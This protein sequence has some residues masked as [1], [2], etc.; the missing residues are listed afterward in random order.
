MDKSTK[1]IDAYLQPVLDM[2]SE[3]QEQTIC[4][5]AGNCMAPLIREGDLLVIKHGNQDI[6]AG[7]VAVYG[8]P[9]EFYVH[10]VITIQK[11]KGH[12]YYVFK[13]D[14][15]SYLRQN[16]SAEQIMGKVIAVQGANG[17]FNF[18]SLFW[19]CVNR[20]LATVIYSSWR[21]SARDTLF[22][23]ALNNCFLIWHRITPSRYSVN[24]TF[25]KTI[26]LVNKWCF[27]MRLF[28]SSTK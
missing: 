22:W 4:P 16:I 3:E 8:E 13:P 10:R 23:K 28:K 26:Y 7:D 2:W 5:I 20:C 6:H 25:L 17:N 19:K 24:L 11:R 12:N 27:R 21:S 18:N 1:V 9:G 14:S 15:Y